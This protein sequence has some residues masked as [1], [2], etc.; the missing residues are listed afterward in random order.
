M[1]N[2]SHMLIN[3][4]LNVSYFLNFFIFFIKRK[5]HKNII[6]YLEDETLLIYY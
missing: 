2:L 5:K 4:I 1:H 6:I 3:I